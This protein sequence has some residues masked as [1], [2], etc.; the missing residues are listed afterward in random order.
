MHFC[1]HRFERVR[2][3]LCL[4]VYKYICV[5]VCVCVRTWSWEIIAVGLAFCLSLDFIPVRQRAVYVVRECTGADL[6]AR[7]VYGMACVS[8]QVLI[9]A[10]VR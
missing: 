8:T 5:C 6:R 3:S 7:A 1:L 2:M 10:R 4:C 9:C